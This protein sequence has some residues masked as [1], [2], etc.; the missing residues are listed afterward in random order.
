MVVMVAQLNSATMQWTGS[1]ALTK[2]NDICGI[3]IVYLLVLLC[4][5]SIPILFTLVNCLNYLHLLFN[6]SQQNDGYVT[7]KTVFAKRSQGGNKSF[8]EI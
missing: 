3:C 8:I 2:T 6:K 5:Y 7:V 1:T 4:F